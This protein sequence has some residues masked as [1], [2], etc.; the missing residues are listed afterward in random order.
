MRALSRLRSLPKKI[1]F[2]SIV[3]LLQAS[4]VAF[5]V[6]QVVREKR[7]LK[8]DIERTIVFQR[9]DSAP[10][11][12]EVLLRADPEFEVFPPARRLPPAGQL[13]VSVTV[14]SAPAVAVDS[15]SSSG[16]ESTSPANIQVNLSSTSA[17]PVTVNYRVTGGTATNGGVDYTLPP[18][19]LTFAP[20]DTTRNIPITIVEDGL[21][22]PDETIEVT[23]YNPVNAVPGADSLHTYTVQD[24]DTG[25]FT[26]Y[27]NPFAAGRE[28]TTITYFLEEQSTISLKLYTLWG[29]PVRTLLEN[30]ARAPG[31]YEDVIWDG[32]NG[33]GHTV[34]NGVYYL[35]L[36]IRGVS[37]KKT[38][39]MRKVGVIR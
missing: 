4:T 16:P 29:A 15:S 30:Q 34:N 19:V 21:F 31:F 5:A 11:S 20:G 6:F 18:G 33:D 12:E 14:I 10:G 37:G 3:V 35:R 28:L 24:N 2:W 25:G 26:N 1:A 36:E 22:E 8:K 13:A 38:A 39:L 7:I 27:P 9:M 32:R 17:L 23:L